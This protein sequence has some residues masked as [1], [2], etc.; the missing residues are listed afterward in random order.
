MKN[1][2]VGCLLAAALFTGCDKDDDDA[3]DTDVNNLDRE[4]VLKASMA[5]TAE[6]DAGQLA[7]A[8]GTN[9]GIISFGQMMVT[10]HSAAK[11]DLQNIAADL[12][13]YAP[14]SLD[15]RHVMLKAQLMTLSGRAFDS[16]YIHSQVQ[17]HQEAIALFE[18][19]A[20]DGDNDRLENYARSLLPHLRNH[21]RVA[22]S[23]AAFYQ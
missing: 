10:D 19:E 2:L 3:N 14:D 5:N 4:F 11:T 16:V 8:N 18:R 22:D 20:D 23:L 13:L 1:Y 6:I 21:L 17:D 12:Q 15:E 7:A 9:E